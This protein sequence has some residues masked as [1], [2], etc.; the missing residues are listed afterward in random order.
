M[1]C[2][3]TIEDYDRS[4][5]E[6]TC[7]GHDASLLRVKPVCAT[8][9]IFMPLIVKDSKRY[10][11]IREPNQKEYGGTLFF[12]QLIRTKSHDHGY[13]YISTTSNQTAAPIL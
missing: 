3:V 6:D 7:T 9:G 5:L 11:V 4:Q 8:H 12:N 2:V 1:M 13:T 10:T